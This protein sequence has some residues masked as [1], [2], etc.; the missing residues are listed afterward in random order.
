M[1]ATEVMDPCV[2][3]GMRARVFA[4]AAVLYVSIDDARV[5]ARARQAHRRAFASTGAV[6]C[7]DRLLR[8]RTWLRLR[9]WL[10]LWL[11]PG[12]WRRGWRLYLRTSAGLVRESSGFIRLTTRVFCICQCLSV[13]S[14]EIH[15]L[16]RKSIAR[17]CCAPVGAPRRLCLPFVVLRCLAQ[18]CVLICQL[19]VLTAKLGIQ[20]FRIVLQRVG[21]QIR[22]S[23][24]LF[25]RDDAVWAANASIVGDGSEHDVLDDLWVVQ[26]VFTAV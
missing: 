2:D 13:P 7:S 18:L 15:Q 22:R 16:S 12:R 23:C 9:L 10:W 24:I 1:A 8:L 26:H 14:A 3:G 5:G 25:E 20:L 17:L 11:R 19:I 21:V 4:P 6:R